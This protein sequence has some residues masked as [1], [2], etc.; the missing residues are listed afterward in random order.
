ME[1]MVRGEREMVRGGGDEEGESRWG[2]V[3]RDGQM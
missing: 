3:T 2:K 1:E